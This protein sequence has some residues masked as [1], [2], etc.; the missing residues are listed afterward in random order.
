MVIFIWALVVSPPSI[1]PYFQLFAFPIIFSVGVYYMFASF[2]AKKLTSIH[3]GCYLTLLYVLL[4]RAFTIEVSVFVV[5]LL[6]AITAVLY[7]KSYYGYQISPLIKIRLRA[8]NEQYGL[9]TK[10]DSLFRN[11]VFLAIPNV[12]RSFIRRKDKTKKKSEKKA[13]EFREIL[14]FDFRKLLFQ[15]IP[16]IIK[17]L[18]YLGIAVGTY[19]AASEV[20]ESFVNVGTLLESMKYYP[21]LTGQIVFL[22]SMFIGV[23]Y[24]FVWLC[25][26]ALKTLFTYV[27]MVDYAYV[28]KARRYKFRVEFYPK[29]DV[30]AECTVTEQIFTGAQWK[31]RGERYEAA[32]EEWDRATFLEF[33]ERFANDKGYRSEF[34]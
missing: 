12:V 10:L 27:Q 11:K 9:K 20:F 19:F 25:H 32:F 13:T 1:E 15:R 7:G 5:V 8:L 2:K 14:R 18:L 29:S 34:L 17:H 4:T 3:V 31:T 28:K 33:K 21:G 26:F 16:P 30:Q 24:L 6:A 23:T 22:I